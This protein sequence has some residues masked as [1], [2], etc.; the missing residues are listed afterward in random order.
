MDWTAKYRPRTFDQ[1]I[2]QPDVETARLMVKRAKLDDTMTP[3]LFVGPPGTGKTSTARVVGAAL[4]CEVSD[5]GACGS[6][7][8]CI[9]ICDGRWASFVETYDSSRYGGVGSMRALSETLLYAVPGGTWRVLILDEAH[10]I[11]REGFTALL[12]PLENLPP[13]NTFVMATTEPDKIPDTIQQRCKSCTFVSVSDEEIIQHLQRL[14]ANE[15]IAPDITALR[16]IAGRAEGSVRNA[17][18]LLDVWALRGSLGAV[19]EAPH[20]DPRRALRALKDALSRSMTRKPQQYRVAAKLLDAAIKARST[21]IAYSVGA[22]QKDAG[23]AKGTVTAALEWLIE[24][25]H[26]E[27]LEPDPDGVPRWRIVLS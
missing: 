16:T 1:I 7:T 11:T 13:H 19:A 17:I 27:E 2:G 24:R 26:I 5:E 23:V 3:L 4:N 15:G 18:H 20:E 9:A 14:A 21:V 10:A 22:L 6:C 25:G 8:S 12:R